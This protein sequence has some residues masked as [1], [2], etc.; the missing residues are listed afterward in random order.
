[1]ANSASKCE[2]CLYYEYD[3]EYG[4]YVC[5]MELDEDETAQFIHGSF[6]D[7]PYYRPGDEYT[8]V[9]KQI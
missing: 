5:D 6:S 1:M 8:I 3:P 2:D 4:F 9:H 7:C